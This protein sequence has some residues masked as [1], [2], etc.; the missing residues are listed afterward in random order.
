MLAYCK[1]SR[2]PDVRDDRTI[3]TILNHTF[4][5]IS[6]STTVRRFGRGSCRQDDQL[7]WVFVADEAPETHKKNGGKVWETWETLHLM[8]VI[9]QDVPRSHLNLWFLWL[10]SLVMKQLVV[11]FLLRVFSVLMFHLVV[12][13]VSCCLFYLLS[14]SWPCMFLFPHASK[15]K[16]TKTS[17]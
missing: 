14:C 15:C 6:W 13:V 10:P 5:S 17:I 1:L 4:S 16:R 11:T 2:M 7:I 9:C 12:S 8:V 3:Q